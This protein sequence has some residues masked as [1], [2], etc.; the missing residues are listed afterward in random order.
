MAAKGIDIHT[1]TW[2][3]VRR[4]AHERMAM[5]RVKLEN[6]ELSKKETQM[7]RAQLIE[8]KQVLAL[9]MDEEAPLANPPEALPE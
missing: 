4:H 2:A 1:G 6:P 9:G 7:A 3:A 5:L 8:L